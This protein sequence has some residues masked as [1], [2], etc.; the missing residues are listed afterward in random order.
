MSLERSI[1]R[2]LITNQTLGQLR[3]FLNTD[4]RVADTLGL[5]GVQFEMCQ[6]GLWIETEIIPV[7]D[8][9]QTSERY[10]RVPSLDYNSQT[11]F[12]EEY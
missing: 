4:E 10:L 2:C 11:S 8:D 7:H 5:E 3:D 9:A 6:Q 1:M 12:L